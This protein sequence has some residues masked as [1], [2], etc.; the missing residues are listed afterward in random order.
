MHTVYPRKIS[1]CYV[2]A[3]APPLSCRYYLVM[4][5]LANVSTMDSACNLIMVAGVYIIILIV[6]NTDTGG[7]SDS[8][9]EELL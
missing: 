7:V 3:L 4:C 2:S 5:Y 6:R 8:K 1:V 9:A